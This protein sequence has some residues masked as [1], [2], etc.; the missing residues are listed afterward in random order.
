M[1]RRKSPTSLPDENTRT[2]T[3]VRVVVSIESQ[4]VADLMEKWTF[5]SPLT[6]GNEGG[7]ED[8]EIGPR[9]P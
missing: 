6:P 2:C 1:T 5:R 7:E 9:G 8:I 3:L 4:K